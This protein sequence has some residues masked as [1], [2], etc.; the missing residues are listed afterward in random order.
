[1]KKLKFCVIGLGYFG[2]NLSL[3]LTELG[4]EV[5][6]IDTREDVIENIK[7]KVELAL[8][9]DTT[10]L[11]ALKSLGIEDIDAVIVAIGEDFEGSINTIANLQEIGVKRIIARSISPI[12]QRLLKLMNI[13]QVILPEAEAAKHLSNKLIIPDIYD[14]IE[15]DN[16]YAIFECKVPSSFVGKKL[17]EIN[18]RQNYDLNLVTIKRNQTKGIFKKSS[19]NSIIGIPMPDYVFQEQDILVIFGTKTKI[20]SFLNSI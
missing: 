5:I 17:L 11:K 1:M 9:M 12:H 14:Y 6:S 20:K 3:Y 10:D 13:D 16:N 18:L 2:Y 4:A 8:V 19:E 7:D 15:L